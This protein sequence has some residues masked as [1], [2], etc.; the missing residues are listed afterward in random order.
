MA[1]LL[2]AAPLPPERWR[3]LSP[4][5][6]QALELTTGELDSWLERMRQHDAGIARDIETLLGDRDALRSATFLE[7]G[8]GPA[9]HAVHAGMRVGA[10]TLVSPLGR[11]GMG[12][13]W[14]ADRS[15][16]RFVGRAAVKLLHASRMGHESEERFRREGHVLARLT[17]DNVA[18]LIDA[19]ITEAGQ[20]YLVL[21]YIEGEHIDRYCEARAMD[22]DARLRLFLSVLD[23]VAHAHTN[24][25]VHRDIKPSNVLV[26]GD[27]TVKLLDFGIAKLLED[28]RNADEAPLT[29]EGAL[30]LTPEYAAPEQVTG[31]A[32][33]TATDVYALGMLLY[34]LLG[35]PHPVSA[36]GTSIA[37]LLEAIVD[38]VPPPVSKASPHGRAMRPDLDAIVGKALNKV[39]L[40]RYA[41]VDGFADDLRRYLRHEPVSVRPA[42]PVYRAGM[43]LRRHAAAAAGV[44]LA[45][46]AAA[47]VVAFHTYRLAEERDRA[48]L[49]ATRS[50]RVADV[51]SGVLSGADPYATEQHEP[52][53]RGLLEAGAAHVR[54]DLADEPELRAEM[55]T[56]IG[57]TQ[58]R[59]G[60]FDAAGRTLEEAIEAGRRGQPAGSLP[61]A[62]ALTQHGVLMRERGDAAA[63][64]AVLDEALA[65]RRAVGADPKDV[66]I[67]LIELGRALEETGALD[68]AEA[69]YREGL[70]IRRAVF[71]EMHRETS[72]ALTD[73][74]LLLRLRG[75]V[76]T[77]ESLLLQALTISRAVLGDDH[78]NVGAAWNNVGLTRLDK[79]DPAG[80]EP[81]LRRALA[82]REA[83][84]GSEHPSLGINLGN[85]AGCLRELGQYDEARRLLERG[86]TLT[87]SGY[88][89]RHPSMAH[90]QYGL[91]VLLL[92]Q[93]DP[94]SAEGVLR[95]AL[96]RQQALMRPDDWRLGVTKS[97]LGAALLALGRPGE[98][99]LLLEEAAA[100]L[101]DVPG[102]QGRE[103][104]RTR[105]RLAALQ[106]LVSSA[107]A[108]AR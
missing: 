90:L 97:A 45:A 63:S 56:V 53:V 34:V 80:A 84:F 50:T 74:G 20:P 25:I 42:T 23:A 4:Y 105:E 2:S 7:R 48:Q 83:Q 17:H 98:A 40:E 21:E 61:L 73:L 108:Q 70:A 106:R 68:R 5:L 92:A 107:P 35:A 47:G 16:G 43:F 36:R 85:L 69:H 41:S 3:V 14:L 52:T 49:A 12:A 37:A 32:V 27:G 104:Q 59:L 91:G 33:T 87:R 22:V 99:R 102:R 18:R 55:L 66:A 10:Y 24:L 19:G 58:Q 30:L 78:P 79:G 103:A 101:Q 38:V 96:A 6:D 95:D 44:L 75:D 13:V 71:G 88:G 15:D 86:L 72:T 8:L 100:V 11:G 94:A 64:V 51:L 89:D 60:L 81:A 1:D 62:F 65:M 54:R 82:I 57:R 77:A 39:P 46:I 93:D 67:T 31:G 9:L 29:V 28:E 76:L 26:R